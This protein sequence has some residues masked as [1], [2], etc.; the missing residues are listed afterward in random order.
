MTEPETLVFSASEWVPNHPFLPVLAYRAVFPPEEGDRAAAFERRFGAAGWRGLWRNG[1]FAYQHYHSGAHEVLGIAGGEAELLI[2]GP[3]G[4][5]LSVRA[6]D[7]L[8][9]PAGTGHRRLSA[10]GDFLVVGGYPPGQ[11]ADILTTE[12]TIDQ[13]AAI[14]ALPVPGSDPLYGADG[15]LVTIWRRA[16]ARA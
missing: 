12:A 8:V 15:P 11:H 7:C 9:L 2:G 5:R 13:L 16:A 4:A 6:G 3:T 14:E 1:V 10:S